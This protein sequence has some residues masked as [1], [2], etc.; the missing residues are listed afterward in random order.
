MKI[1]IPSKLLPLSPLPPW[2][3]RALISK[4]WLWQ[5]LY[6]KAK[7][8]SSPSLSQL[9]LS[10]TPFPPHSKIQSLILSLGLTLLPLNSGL[11]SNLFEGLLPQFPHSTLMATATNLTLIKLIVLTLFYILFQY[12][13]SS[14]QPHSP[15]P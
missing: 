6:L 1:Y 3:N 9:P 4:I 2:I 11:L 12:L 10:T 13:C 8:S 15:I 14:S 5:H 7:S